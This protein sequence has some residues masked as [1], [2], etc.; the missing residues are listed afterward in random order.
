[1]SDKSYQ[2]Y[3]MLGLETP[4]RKRKQYGNNTPTV[5]SVG[6]LFSN[7]ENKLDILL[8]KLRIFIS[9]F[10]LEILTCSYPQQ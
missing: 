9:Y 10:L 6:L 7:K 5:G 1:M 3:V 8:S 2:M 4:V